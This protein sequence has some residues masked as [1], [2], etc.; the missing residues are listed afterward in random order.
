MGLWVYYKL[1][2][3]GKFAYFDLIESQN[4]A[5]NMEEIL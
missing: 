3:K 4:G 1:L 5:L 2:V